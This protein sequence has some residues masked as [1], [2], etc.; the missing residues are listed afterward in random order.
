MEADSRIPTTV[1]VC[2]VALVAGGC[3][4]AGEGPPTVGEAG[5]FL[6]EAEQTLLARGI[7]EARH[8]WIQSTFITQDTETLYAEANARYIEAAVD[9]AKRATRYAELELPEEQ[10]RQ[11]DLL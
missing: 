10:R 9:L 2:L 3:P 7:D 1:L 11:L 4:P 6:A 5:T 8:G